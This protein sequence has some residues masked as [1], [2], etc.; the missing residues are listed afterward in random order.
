MRARILQLLKEHIGPSPLENDIISELQELLDSSEDCELKR[1]A[2]K[3][4]QKYT[5]KPLK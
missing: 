4:I 3:L 5:S 2:Q 1:E